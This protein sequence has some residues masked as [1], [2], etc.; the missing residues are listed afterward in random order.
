V[1]GNIFVNLDQKSLQKF[2]HP[3]ILKI[4]D[5]VQNIMVKDMGF[6]LRLFIKYNKRNKWIQIKRE[7]KWQ[8][9]LI[10]IN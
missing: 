4:K 9:W 8:I 6:M 7:C 1:T 10:N 2:N 5:A 3:I